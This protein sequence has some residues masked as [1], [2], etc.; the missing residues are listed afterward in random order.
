VNDLPVLYPGAYGPI[1]IDAS[2]LFL[3][4]TPTGSQW[5]GVGVTGNTFDPS[6]AGAGT[7]TLTYT[8]SVVGGC[9]VDTAVQVVVNA[10]PVVQT[11]S[12]GPY[13]SQDDPITLSATPTGGSWS[14]I[15][16]SGAIFSPSVAGAGTHVITYYY[17]DQWG[18]SAIGE[19]NII[20]NNCAVTNACTYTQ[21]YY[22]S[23]N[24]KSC[25]QDSLYRNA[26][27]L[28]KKLL[29]PSPLVIGSGTR[30]LTITLNDSARLN[31]VMPGGGTPRI[32][33]HTGNITLSSSQFAAYRS[34]N[35]RINNVLLSQT[36]TLGLNLRIKDDLAPFI[37]QNGYLHTQRTRSCTEGSGVY[38]C[39]EDTMAIKAWLMKKTVIDYLQAISDGTVLDLFNLA[40][41][42]LG[43]VK[44]P[45][46]LVNGVAVVPTLSDIVYQIDVIN[47]AFDKCRVFV[48]YYPI[49]TLCNSTLSSSSKNQSVV[50]VE[51][52]EKVVVKAFPNPFHSIVNFSIYSP[53][54]TNITIEL[55]DM[56]G[57]LISKAFSGVLQ[58]NENRIIALNVGV[59]K[60]PI[61]YRVVV[62]QKIVTGLLLPVQ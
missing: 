35:G 17:T 54:L 55:F 7:H 46:Q 13:C 31:A 60:A 41:Q 3:Q 16:I 36:I 19:T 49:P 21:G 22:G 4:A 29:M 27:S 51:K 50:T 15:G 14:G 1:C 26:I 52:N 40:N 33:S 48:D 37:L 43:G 44:V 45:G 58:A 28:I 23:V 9:V 24:G 8:L 59:T 39:S 61:A 25:D 2:P 6:E 57:K 47:N 56:Q 53:I 5:S 38:N 18:C 20:V 32:F 12:Y 10:L 11:G 62:A 42:V 30:T 34:S